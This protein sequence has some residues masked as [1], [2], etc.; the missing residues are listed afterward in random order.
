MARAIVGGRPFNFD[1]DEI[2][3]RMIGVRPERIQKELVEMF[4]TVYPPKQVVE[5][6]T[7]WNR[8][9]FT[10]H[11]AERV[12]TKAG[13]VCRPAGVDDDGRPGRFVEQPADD[14]A[15]SASH[16]ETPDAR[17]ARV[18]TALTINQEAIASLVRRVE[19][20]EASAR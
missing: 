5:T 7:G 18:E 10:T 4:D 17:L 19:K 8:R 3:R 14:G 2:E 9:T 16:A 13:F 12:L 11:E 15:E 1:R 20:L 6:V